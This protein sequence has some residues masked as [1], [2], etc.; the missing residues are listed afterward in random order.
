[1]QVALVLED[2]VVMVVLDLTAVEQIIKVA[3]VAV[4]AVLALLEQLTVV[5]EQVA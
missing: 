5:A 4:L 3:V 1:V 2:K